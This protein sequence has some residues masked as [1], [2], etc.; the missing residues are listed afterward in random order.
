M[1]FV[2]VAGMPDTMD[3]DFL[4]AHGARNMDRGTLQ[5]DCTRMRNLMEREASLEQADFLS[6]DVEGGEEF[7]LKASNLR[8]FKLMLVETGADIGKYDRQ[9]ADAVSKRQRI[10]AMLKEAG[11]V[12]PTDGPLAAVSTI[13]SPMRCSTV[14]AHGRGAAPLGGRNRRDDEVDEARRAEAEDRQGSEG[15]EAQRGLNYTPSGGSTGGKGT[16]VARLH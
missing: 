10:L 9:S 12:K 6:L 1:N 4:K 15:A 13:F 11:F 5:V 16:E 14:R 7:V 8:D 2:H 3:T